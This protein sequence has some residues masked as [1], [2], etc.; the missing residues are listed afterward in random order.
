MG[1]ETSKVLQMKM[2]FLADF[3]VFVSALFAIARGNHV[4]GCFRDEQGAAD[5]DGEAQPGGEGPGGAGAGEGDAGERGGQAAR[6]HFHAGADQQGAP[7]K[8]SHA[9][10]ACPVFEC[11]CVSECAYVCMCVCVMK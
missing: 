7:A 8:G 6:Q 2:T 1:S 9:C 4:L 11:V 10:W 5:A 3:A